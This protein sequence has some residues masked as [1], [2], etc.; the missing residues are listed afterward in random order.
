MDHLQVA[1][2]ETKQQLEDMSAL[3]EAQKSKLGMVEGNASEIEEAIR[4]ASRKTDLL[5][6]QAIQ[7]Q[8]KMESMAK[9]GK[10][11]PKLLSDVRKIYG[12]LHALREDISSTGTA[13]VRIEDRIDAA[14]DGFAEFDRMEGEMRFAIE[15]AEEKRLRTAGGN[16]WADDMTDAP[17][18]SPRFGDAG[19]GLGSGGALQAGPR[20][21]G[22]SQSPTGRNVSTELGGGRRGGSRERGGGMGLDAMQLIQ[23]MHDEL[24]ARLNSGV[25]EAMS[26]AMGGG[27]ESDHAGRTHSSLAM[28]NE[29]VGRIVEYLALDTKMPASRTA[30]RP[31]SVAAVGEAVVP[32]ERVASPVGRAPQ[33]PGAGRGPSAAA[34]VAS[35]DRQPGSRMATPDVGR[36]AHTLAG[37]IAS[38]L[39]R[40]QDER[41]RNLE[42]SIGRKIEE[43]SRRAATPSTLSGDDRLKLL[44][45]E[46][47]EKE[48]RL[49]LRAGSAE[50]MVGE[51]QA[52]IKL[53]ASMRKVIPTLNYWSSEASC[54]EGAQGRK[55]L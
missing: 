53:E 40:K 13:R 20:P 4:R 44:R 2:K 42:D 41:L 45:A 16:H 36:K 54:L 34:R 3:N 43:M 23:E 39:S 49:E 38:E 24:E 37:D 29:S 15:Q 11:D 32:G 8:A 30:S 47:G 35:P 18:L 19:A 51:L 33:S 7:A 25:K 10:V 9:E 48:A 6:R 22:A 27:E 28:V 17:P 31:A 5:S 12:E 50:S 14:H 1:L 26:I 46:Y 52:K 21:G 55:S